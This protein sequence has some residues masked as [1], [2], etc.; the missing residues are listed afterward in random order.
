MKNFDTRFEGFNEFFLR[1][2]TYET[3]KAIETEYTFLHRNTDCGRLKPL[4]LKKY[5]S[6]YFCLKNLPIVHSSTNITSCE[7]I[8]N[9]D[10]PEKL[11]CDLIRKQFQGYAFESIDMFISYAL[12]SYSTSFSIR[13]P[14]GLHHEYLDESAQN[15]LVLLKRITKDIVNKFEDSLDIPIWEYDWDN[16]IPRP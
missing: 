15:I 7:F 12:C 11:G 8:I 1:N 4:N 13:I 9:K 6:K 10:F 3:L 14:L 2:L 16:L 5:I